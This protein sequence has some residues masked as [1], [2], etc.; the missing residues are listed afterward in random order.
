MP[1]EKPIAADCPVR[2]AIRNMETDHHSSGHDTEPVV[3]FFLLGPLVGWAMEEFSNGAPH[4]YERR[5]LA[6]DVGYGKIYTIFHRGD[7]AVNVDIQ[8][9]NR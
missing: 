5:S 7:I 6:N 1:N 9:A 4:T 3:G 2:Y 8:G